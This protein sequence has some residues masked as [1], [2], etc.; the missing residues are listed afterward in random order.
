MEIVS[1]YNIIDKNLKIM[2]EDYKNLQLEYND[3]IVKY[4]EK[5]KNLT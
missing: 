2:T 1:E 4:E 5:I 3:T